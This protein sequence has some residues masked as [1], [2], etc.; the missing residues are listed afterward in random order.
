MLPTLL[1]AIAAGPDPG[2]ALNRFTDIVDRMSSGVNL[3]RLLEA[4]PRLG[5][6][7]GAD[8]GSC[9]GAGRPARAAARICSTG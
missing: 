6:D 2:R 1:R 7:P 5:V 3:Y 4:R 8:S 9:A